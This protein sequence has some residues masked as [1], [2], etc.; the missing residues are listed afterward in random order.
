MSMGM[1]QIAKREEHEWRKKQA[2]EIREMLFRN[3]QPDSMRAAIKEIKLNLVF[4]VPD[5][6]DDLEGLKSMV[7]RLD[8]AMEQMGKGPSLGRSGP[9]G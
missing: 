9:L 1:Y 8:A 7:E 4:K 6:N 3:Q 2:K 5:S